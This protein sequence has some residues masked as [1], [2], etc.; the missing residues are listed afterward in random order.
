[1]DSLAGHAEPRNGD[2]GSPNLLAIKE[3]FRASVEDGFEA[4]LEALLRLSPRGL[5]VPPVHR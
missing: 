1:M 5:R 3:A 4:G 2:P